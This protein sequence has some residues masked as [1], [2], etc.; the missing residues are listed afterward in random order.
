MVSTN[1]TVLDLA[2]FPVEEGRGAGDVTWN[3]APAVSD[4]ALATAAVGTTLDPIIVDVTNLVQLWHADPWQNFGTMLSGVGADRVLYS[5]AAS[6]LGSYPT[7]EVT[8]Q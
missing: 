3:T 1:E 2:L 5:F 6:E 4:T 7:L 8:F